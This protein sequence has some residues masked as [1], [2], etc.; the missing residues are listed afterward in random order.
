MLEVAIAPQAMDT[1]VAVP[2]HFCPCLETQGS[3]TALILLEAI[4]HRT[5]RDGTEAQD[6]TKEVAVIQ[7][8]IL[9]DTLTKRWPMYHGN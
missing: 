7:V 9:A 1:V 6:E 4:W 5:N 2:D 8:S 3:R